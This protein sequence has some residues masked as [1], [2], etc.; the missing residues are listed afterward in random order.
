MLGEDSGEQVVGILDGLGGS[1]DSA[2][3]DVGLGVDTKIGEGLL[4]QGDECA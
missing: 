3:V 4:C 2:L 1:D